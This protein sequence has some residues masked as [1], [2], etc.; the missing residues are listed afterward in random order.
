[1]ESENVATSSASTQSS[2]STYASVTQKTT[3]PT[4]DQ[5]IILD[6][7]EDIS[8]KEYIIAIG[9]V[10]DPTNIRFASRIANNRI[11]VYLASKHLVDKIMAEKI[12]INIQ[13]R[14]LSVRPFITKAKRIILSNV[15]PIIPHMELET[16]MK[17]ME[18][19][20]LSPISFIKAGFTESGFTHILSFRRQIYIHPEDENK[21]PEYLQVNYD[22]T[23][24]WIFVSSD[25]LMCFL[26]KKEGHM[27]KQ[28]PTLS[29][30]ESSVSLNNTFSQEDQNTSKN[31]PLE[32]QSKN[33]ITSLKND[34]NII[35]TS[36]NKLSKRPLS[37]SA[38]SES[39]HVPIES[40]PYSEKP[41]LLST[42]NSSSTIFLEP[43]LIEKI[44]TPIKKKPKKESMEAKLEEVD[45]S[46]NPIKEALTLHPD[47]YALNYN[48]LCDFLSKSKGNT[49]IPQLA[50]QY[51]PNITHL[52]RILR[53]TYPCLND[54]SMKNRFS[55][56]I[57]KL[58]HYSSWNENSSFT[59]ESDVTT[60]DTDSDIDTPPAPNDTYS[61]KQPKP[62]HP[63]QSTQ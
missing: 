14:I 56:I 19:R 52:T 21:L 60:L 59:A 1:M 10:I 32:P 35:L 16:I 11:C 5:A 50:Q 36:P 47:A 2:N 61:S 58:E 51:S 29:N 27:A 26:C 9:K 48:Q 22:N 18:I 15:C 41:A 24:Y 28:C 62:S 46:L 44:S 30:K 54:R 33:I 31:L 55:R 40:D 45:R 6:A 23:T 39:T 49:N 12:N 8:I 37:E 13:G 7:Y 42:P 53:D 63:L 38:S 20:L 4:K 34:N 17:K 43:S 3:F 57:K 25:K